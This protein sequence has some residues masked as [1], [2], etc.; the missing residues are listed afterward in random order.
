LAWADALSNARGD[1]ATGEPEQVRTWN[2]ASLWRLPRASGVVWLKVVPPFFAHE[3]PLIAALQSEAVPR[4]LGH[5]GGRVLLADVAGIDLYEATLDQRLSM[6]DLLVDL[7]SRWR[8]R[9]DELLSL[10]LPDWRAPALCAAI[11]GLIDRRADV[12]EPADV[13]LLAAFVDDLPLRCV[14]IEACG[15][16]EGLVHGDFHPGNLRGGTGSSLTLLD[17]GD[18]GVGHPLLGMPAFLDRSPV[19]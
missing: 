4:V 16:S 14:A 5:D 2:L 3:G 1:A 10:G 11:A 13:P 6:I 19:D 7:Q 9:V 17:W 8:T 12:L 15:V 18:S